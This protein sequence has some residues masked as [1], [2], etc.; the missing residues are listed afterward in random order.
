MVTEKHKV[1]KVNKRDG[2]Q[3]KILTTEFGWTINVFPQSVLQAINGFIKS[4]PTEPLH[5]YLNIIT[6]M[7]HNMPHAM[8][9]I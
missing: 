7:V 2:P 3:K 6:S 9:N 8:Y 5:L 1:T 4:P